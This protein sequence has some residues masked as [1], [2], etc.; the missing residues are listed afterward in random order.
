[1]HKALKICLSIPFPS[2]MTMVK[3]KETLKTYPSIPFGYTFQTEIYF[4]RQNNV[5]TL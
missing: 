5:S 4:A 1:M 2:S 3:E